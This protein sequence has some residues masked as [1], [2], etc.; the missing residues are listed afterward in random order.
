VK[1]DILEEGRSIHI[2][3]PYGEMKQSLTTGGDGKTPVRVENHMLPMLTDVK[4]CH[5]HF[6]RYQGHER[7]LDY[8]DRCGVW[9]DFTFEG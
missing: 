1:M 7:Q 2:K 8:C 3:M 9:A 4:T 6:W 5:T